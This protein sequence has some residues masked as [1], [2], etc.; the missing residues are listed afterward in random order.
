MELF[1]KAQLKRSK[2]S[3]SFLLRTVH[4]SAYSHVSLYICTYSTLQCL[5]TCKSVHMYVSM[6]VPTYV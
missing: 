4:C 3:P 1:D 2:F 6:C 5:L